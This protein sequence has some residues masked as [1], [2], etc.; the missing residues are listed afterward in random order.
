MWPA[1]ISYQ[2]W[3]NRGDYYLW[4]GH[5]VFYRV[6]DKPD[7]EAQESLALEK[8]SSDKPVLLLIHGFPTAGW[9][10]CWVT[11]TLCQYFTLIVPDLLD[12]GLSENQYKRTCSI[13]DQAAMLEAL[14]RELGFDKAHIL[15]H[16]V[17]DTVAQELFAHQQARNLDFRILSSVFLNGGMLPD[18]H[19]PR[20]AQLALAG[21]LG[22]LWARLVKR[23]KMLAGFADVFG[24]NTRPEGEFLNEF[25]PVMKGENGRSSFAR[26]IRY[27]LERK[28]YADRW[29]GALKGTTVP[30][31]LINGT[32]DPVS[33]GHAAD[34]FE[35]RIPNA[36][37]KRLDGIGHYPQIE[38]PDDVL[39]HILAFHNL[40]ASPDKA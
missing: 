28:Q 18:L 36:T 37:V 24:S 39:N 20:P 4:N 6:I 19:R 23:E 26:R 2:E 22:W 1:P 30:L 35:K 12:Y 34:G 32:A 11:D 25:W 15:A 16:D 31:I 27:M 13:L 21:K 5:K 10:W 7:S 33:G 38:A 29:V 9:D 8:S 40:D 17:G 3:K 14:M